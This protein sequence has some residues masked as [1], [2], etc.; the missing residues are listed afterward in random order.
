M[1][2]RIE[3]SPVAGRRSPVRSAVRIGLT[4][5]LLLVAP[6]AVA[7]AANLTDVQA[8]RIAGED[9]KVEDQ[10]EKNGPLGTSAEL[11]GGD[12]DVA[13]FA[14]DAQ[15]A[16]V[17]VDDASGAVLEAWTGYQATWKM[18][19]GYE[20]QFGHK[21]NAPYVFLPLCV[22]FLIGLVDWRRPRQ[23]AHVDL[24][25]L[26]G[27]GVSH[28]FFNRGEIGL[29]VPLVYAPL[30]YLTGRLLWIGFRGRAEPLRPVWPAAWLLVA[31]LF[32]VG[33]RGG[34]NVADS[35]VIDVGYASVVGADRLADG[36]P[37]YGDFPDDVDQ[38]DTYGPTTYLAYVPFEQALPWRGSWDDLPAAHAAAVFFDLGTFALLWLLGRR[39]R[40]G[41][42]GRT[43]GAT[44]AFGW[45]AYPYAAFALQANSNDTLVGLLAVA[46]LLL[47]AR[48]LARGAGAAALALTKLAPLVLAPLLAVA[49]GASRRLLV[50]FAL[51]FAAAGLLLLGPALIDPGAGT[52][53]DRTLGYQAG[54]DSPFSVWGQA[55]LEPVRI[56]VMAATA[57][58][59]LLVALRPPAGD[60][61]RVA[62]LAGALLIGTQLAAQH[63]FYLYIVW[64]FPLA[65]VALAVRPE[66]APGSARSPRR[67]RRRGSSP[68]PPSPRH[69]R[70]PSRTAPASASG[71]TPAPP[72]S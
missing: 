48:P 36:E 13:F 69:P 14:G 72:P 32:L 43:L 37:L 42:E 34:L 41:D 1:D 24:L 31:A 64:F 55:G 65:L 59:A 7:E 62:A 53:A 12:W 50:R 67:G 26:L 9:P 56:A 8:T 25:V 46:A 66:T 71:T 30:L 70:R 11:E 3:R 68:E 61:A 49:G 2:V 44:L 57:A 60:V 52:F 63:W 16:Q 28:F 54:R 18:A 58:L 5:F 10:R 4:A 35:G 27:F 51:G 17:K 6:P 47:I 29:S 23:I 20:G 21:L 45:A 39:L 15:V 33:F 38:G 19:R 22:L 40:P